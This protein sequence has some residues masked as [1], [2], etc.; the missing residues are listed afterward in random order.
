MPLMAMPDDKSE[1]RVAKP[2]TSSR[3]MRTADVA[4]AFTWLAA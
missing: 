1:S 4:A 3:C 2:P